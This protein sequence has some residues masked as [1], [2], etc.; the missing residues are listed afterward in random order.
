MCLAIQRQ[1]VLSL[2]LKYNRNKLSTSEGLLSVVT[3]SWLTESTTVISPYP[4]HSACRN[5]SELQWIAMLQYF[6]IHGLYWPSLIQNR[7][8]PC[9]EQPNQDYNIIPFPHQYLPVTATNLLRV[10]ITVLQKMDEYLCLIEE[11]HTAL[12]FF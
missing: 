4:N 8:L 9:W 3:S 6:F 11:I 12:F 7:C 2:F 10:N 5:L 1:H